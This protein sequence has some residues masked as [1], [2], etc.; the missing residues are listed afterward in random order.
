MASADFP[1][2]RQEDRVT[3]KLTPETADHIRIDSGA[4][5]APQ[6]ASPRFGSDAF[7]TGGEAA[8]LNTPADYGKPAQKKAIPGAAKSDIAATYRVGDFP[9]ALPLE[10]GRYAVTLT[11]VEPNA[12][13]GERQFDVFANG[14]VQI[15]RLDV[16]SEAGEPRR[17]ITRTF[18][19]AVRLGVLELHFRP[20]SGQAL[21]SAIQVERR[22]F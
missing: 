12:K 11:F 5:M 6:E 2:G 16:A 4:L 13:P 20:G 7:F 8:T 1:T 21:V 14:H 19:V 15:G 22:A 3:W 10:N 17:A 9:Y 18:S